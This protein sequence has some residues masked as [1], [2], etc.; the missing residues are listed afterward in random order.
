MRFVIKWNNGFWKIFDH[1]YYTDVKLC[2]T[3]QEA[4]EIMEEQYGSSKS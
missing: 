1:K 2:N 4:K 3:E